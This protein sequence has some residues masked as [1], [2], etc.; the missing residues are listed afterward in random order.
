M[1][2]EPAH[3]GRGAEV[4]LG[5]GDG[6]QEHDGGRNDAEREGN[7][8]VELCHFRNRIGAQVV[9]FLLLSNPILRSQLQK[10]MGP[11]LVGPEDEPRSSSTLEDAPKS[12][13]I[14]WCDLVEV[15]QP[16]LDETP[17]QPYL[18]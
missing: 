3:I 17:C 12:L 13:L 10:R 4:Q 2:R 15:L 16:S 9:P 8:D 1:S 11:S 6:E 18:R 14:R 7:S 5:P